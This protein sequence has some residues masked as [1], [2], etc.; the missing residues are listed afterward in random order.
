MD[1]AKIRKFFREEVFKKTI[2]NCLKEEE[3]WENMRGILVSVNWECLDFFI[4]HNV[5]WSEIR[6][7]II[8]KEQ[9]A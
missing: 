9:T 6:L 5:I 2:S 7:C 8:K 4:R 3:I 1:G